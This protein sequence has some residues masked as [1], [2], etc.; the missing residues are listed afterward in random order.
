MTKLIHHVIQKIGEQIAKD[1]KHFRVT[2]LNETAFT[3]K[4]RIRD[5]YRET[6]R[7]RQRLS[8]LKT[9]GVKLYSRTIVKD[10]MCTIIISLRPINKKVYA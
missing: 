10:D 9:R 6:K 7:L 1:L 5:Q 3:I 4:F 2:L 8:K